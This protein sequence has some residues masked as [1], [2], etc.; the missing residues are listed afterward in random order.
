MIT[1]MTWGSVLTEYRQWLYAAGR[2]P[3]TIR[4]R[5]VYLLQLASRTSSPATVTESDLIAYLAQPWA[6]ETRR[7][8]VSSLRVFF[9][10]AHEHDLIGENPA[11]R[12]P[13]ISIPPT[14]PRPAPEIV[15]AEALERATQ[16]ERLMV[17]LGAFEGLR[18]GEIAAVHSRDIEGLSLRVCGK[19]GRTRLIPLHPTV[20]AA[21]AACDGFVFP[22]HHAGHISPDRVG[23]IM[24]QLLGSGWTTHTLR[25]RFASNAYAVQRDIRAVQE[26]LGH[27]TLTT[28]QRYVAVPDDALRTAV[29][30]A[31]LVA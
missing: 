28:T 29:L 7:S 14:K 18:R 10:W 24:H 9:T 27:S 25:H 17:L 19:G 3:H 30:G 13:T 21:L 11:K 22:G 4:L 2:S 20:A 31:S 5:M 23:R 1:L 15:I 12:L 26:L 8:A 16:R 6:P